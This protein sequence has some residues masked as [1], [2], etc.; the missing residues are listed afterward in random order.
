[1]LSLNLGD[2]I[3]CVVKLYRYFHNIVDNGWVG[4]AGSAVSCLVDAFITTTANNIMIGSLGMLVIERYLVLVKRITNHSQE[5]KLA[6]ASVWIGCIAYSL[7]FA[8]KNDQIDV[9]EAAQ[10]C[11]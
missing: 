1:M 7:C 9:N 11:Q 2:T 10:S 4:G 3:F 8:S 5:T 6:I